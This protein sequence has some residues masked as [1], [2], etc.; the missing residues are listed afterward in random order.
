MY[1][2]KYVYKIMFY[3][4]EKTKLINFFTIT[5]IKILKSLD[6]LLLYFEFKAIY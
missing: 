6:L 1:I 4:L 5:G 2:H 3:E